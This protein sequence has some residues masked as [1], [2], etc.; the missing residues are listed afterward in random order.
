MWSSLERSEVF[1]TSGNSRAMVHE[2]A[3]QSTAQKPQKFILKNILI[4]FTF[5]FEFTEPK[6]DIKY[7]FDIYIF[8][9][10]S[11]DKNN[12]KIYLQFLWSHLS[13][14]FVL[15]CFAIFL[16]KNLNFRKVVSITKYLKI[17]IYLEK[18]CPCKS[19]WCFATKIYILQDKIPPWFERLRSLTETSVKFFIKLTSEDFY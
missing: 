17:K 5:L 15:F 3:I 8:T 16:L 6:F 12:L 10:F 9:S 4:S 14:R 1:E 2:T 18:N 7:L 19:L 11:L 13:Q